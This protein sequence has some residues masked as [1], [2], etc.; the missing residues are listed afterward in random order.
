MPHL[1][2]LLLALL[3][4]SSVPSL[5]ASCDPIATFADGKT[6]LREI[7]LSPSGSN[8]SG[9]GS[10]ANPFQ[11]LSRAVQ[12]IRPG[13]AV[14]LLP[15]TYSPGNHLANLSGTAENPI[16]LGGVPGEARPLIEGGSTAIQLSRVRFLVL[17]N[18]EI[19]GASANGVNCDDGG[20]YANPDAT[21][22]VL[23]R[24]L[25]IHDIGTG[26][27][28]DGLKLSGVDDYFVLDCEFAR[29]SAGGSGIDHVGCHG[30]LIARC[31]FTDMGSNA[32]Q[33]KGGSEDIEIRWNRFIR[34]GSRAINIGGSTGFAFFRPPLSATSPNWEAKNIRVLANLFSGS[35]APAAFVGSIDSIV[36]NNTII[37]PRRWVIRILQETVSDGMH[38]YLPSGGNEFSNN[39][40]HYSRAAIST[41]VNVGSNTAADSFT[42]AHNLWYAF[43]QPSRSQ[44]SL[45]A[46]EVNPVIGEHPQFKDA[47]GGDYTLLPESPAAAKGK[48]MPSLKADL[49][50]RCYATPPSLG[51]FEATLPEPPRADADGDQ[52]PDHWEIAHSFD[53]SDPADASLDLDGDGLSNLG[54]FL[55]GTNPADPGSLLKIAPPALVSGN[56]CQFLYPTRP[57]RS[58]VVQSRPFGPDAAWTSCPLAP[59]TGEPLHFST[60]ITPGG[61]ALFRVAIPA[62]D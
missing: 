16:W 26:G 45:P 44:P 18:L 50:E 21:R 15:G 6:P 31:S 41:H 56:H 29:M 25:F 46:P 55:A 24:N 34:G 47:A 20:D 58:Y 9:D 10:R 42:F 59:G 1:R 54:E 4:A 43:D 19:S 57:G 23:F 60:P 17:E 38:E 3:F 32:I 5:A 13:D 7:F 2:F 36:A 62:A 33:C 12:N 53:P 11:T 48:P 49:L 8:S 27:N 52:T 28:N 37:E 22:H 61:H 39:L 14:R 51:A 40:I 30:G 35:D